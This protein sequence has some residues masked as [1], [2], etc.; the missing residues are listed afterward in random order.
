MAPIISFNGVAHQATSYWQAVRHINQYLAV[1]STLATEDPDVLLYEAERGGFELV[2]W[3]IPDSDGG[4]F[5]FDQVFVEPNTAF[6]LVDVGLARYA[7]MYD[8]F[9]EAFAKMRG[10]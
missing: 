7:G 6:E 4:Y 3:F 2:G 8:T 1:G 5:G 9:E 10:E